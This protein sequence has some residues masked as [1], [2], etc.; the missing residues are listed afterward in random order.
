MAV[1]QAD[2]ATKIAVSDILSTFSD[3]Y[4]WQDGPLAD[5]RDKIYS[6]HQPHTVD[7]R[8]LSSELGGSDEIGWR[9][10]SRFLGLEPI[11][12]S[13]T[14]LPLIT[15]HSEGAWV[16][17]RVY[18]LVTLIGDDS[19]LKSMALR[20]ETD[21]NGLD[22]ENIAGAHNF[23]HAQLCKSVGSRIIG[24]TPEWLPE[25]TPAIPLDA[26]NQV[27]LVLCMLTALYGGEH[28]YRKLSSS[29]QRDL[30]KYLKKVRALSSFIPDAP[31]AQ[32]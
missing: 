24:S 8:G 7:P 9:D 5:H 10:N 28:V 17:F 16:I 3:E 30:L 29:G 32:S 21:E 31:D 13:K 26:D 25:S 11:K 22:P 19:N 27:S 1:K 6:E 18:A 4:A 23:C 15:L 14:Y 2:M 20:F 12:G